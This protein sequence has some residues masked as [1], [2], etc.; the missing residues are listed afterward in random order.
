MA[1]RIPEEVQV[2]HW[3]NEQKCYVLCMISDLQS[4]VAENCAILGYY[5]AASGNF[6]PTF[7]KSRDPWDSVVLE[8]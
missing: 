3:A 4:E 5:A 6:L 7:R 2:K 1:V 8:S